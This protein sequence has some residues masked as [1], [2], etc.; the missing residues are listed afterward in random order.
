M[1]TVTFRW[2]HKTIISELRESAEKT[3]VLPVITK[4][5]KMKGGKISPVI[6]QL[7]TAR[8]WPG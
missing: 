1:I 2:W 5:K 6:R 3:E 7:Q 4:K 8:L